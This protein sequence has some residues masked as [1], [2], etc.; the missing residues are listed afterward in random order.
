MIKTKDHFKNLNQEIYKANLTKLTRI[1][2]NV[3]ITVAQKT[4][5]I[6]QKHEMESEKLLT[7]TK[8]L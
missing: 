1:K 7:Y 3:A 4:K 5:Q 8:R 6:F 2:P